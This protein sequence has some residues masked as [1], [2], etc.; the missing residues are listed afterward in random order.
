M[1]MVKVCCYS[2]V[3]FEIALV[4]EWSTLQVNAKVR[5]EGRWLHLLVNS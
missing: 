1:K 3:H 5:E 4:Q 2:S